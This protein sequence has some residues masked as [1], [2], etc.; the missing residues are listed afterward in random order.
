MLPNAALK[1]SCRLLYESFESAKFRPFV[2]SICITK[3]V[4]I[5]QDAYGGIVSTY[6]PLEHKIVVIDFVKKS[7]DS[8]LAVTSEFS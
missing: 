2:T 6:C 1:K 3:L 7:V 4:K 5:V 8:C